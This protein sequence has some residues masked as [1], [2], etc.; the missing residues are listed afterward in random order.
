[1]RPAPGPEKS[2]GPEPALFPAGDVGSPAARPAPLVLPGAERVTPAPGLRGEG[3]E[4][5]IPALAEPLRAVQLHDLDLVVEVPGGML[6]IDQHALHE[7]ILFEQAR[8]RLRC[9][10]LAVQRLLVPEPVSLPARQAALVLEHREALAAL[11]LAVEDFGGS[12]VLLTGYP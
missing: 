11:G 7:R 9:G 8:Q 12:T 5:A 1:G 10:P 6:V 4:E 2:P 3:K